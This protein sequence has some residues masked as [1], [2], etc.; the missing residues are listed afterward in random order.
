LRG[1]L[2]PIVV[3]HRSAI[4]DKKLLGDFLSLA[5]VYPSSPLVRAALLLQIMLFARPG[6]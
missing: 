1:A 4:L 3:R 6:E 5:R 2:K